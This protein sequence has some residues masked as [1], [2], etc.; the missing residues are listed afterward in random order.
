[1]GV[2]LLPHFTPI[3]QSATTNVIFATPTDTLTH[4]HI[5]HEPYKETIEDP[6][7]TGA[8]VS[9]PHIRSQV[10]AAARTFTGSGGVVVEVDKHVGPG[11]QTLDDADYHH[12]QTLP[13]TF[14]T[15]AKPAPASFATMMTL[16][17]GD[18]VV[19]TTTTVSS[20]PLQPC[21]F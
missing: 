11:G 4:Y 14:F 18:H 13:T 15:T 16:S 12:T 19:E 21:L 6:V 2:Q 1:V 5:Q 3:A 20:F 17:N 10:A 9:Q 8:P 7:T